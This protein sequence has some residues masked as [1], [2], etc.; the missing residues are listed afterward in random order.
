MTVA[1]ITGTEVDRHCI[2]EIIKL[3]SGI[4]RPGWFKSRRQSQSA[5]LL[6]ASSPQPPVY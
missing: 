4:E 2:H 1:L 3:P 6:E 5:S